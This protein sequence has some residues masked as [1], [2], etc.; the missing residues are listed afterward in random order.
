MTQCSTKQSQTQEQAALAHGVQAVAVVIHEKDHCLQK[1]EQ[2]S[3]DLQ[4]HSIP[5]PKQLPN[6]AETHEVLTHKR[7]LHC[8]QW[9]RSL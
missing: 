1:L 8:I 6:A 4:C 7:V 2:I 5:R 3:R 9:T